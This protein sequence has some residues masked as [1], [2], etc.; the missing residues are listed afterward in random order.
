MTGFTLK[1]GD[2]GL[3]KIGASDTWLHKGAA[4]F[5]VSMTL[6]PFCGTVGWRAPE[7]YRT[8]SLSCQPET[9]NM[10]STTVE[11]QQLSDTCVTLPVCAS[12]L[13]VLAPVCAGPRLL[14]RSPD[15]VSD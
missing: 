5:D 8:D 14:I 7:L 3:A 1:L 2:F 9:M 12:P 11:E 4:N 10:V 13:H 15:P 6:T